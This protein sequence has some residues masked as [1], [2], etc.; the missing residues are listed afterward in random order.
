[1]TQTSL[2]A[3]RS[4]RRGEKLPAPARRCAAVRSGTSARPKGVAFQHRLRSLTR[5]SLCFSSTSAAHQRHPLRSFTRAT[6]LRPTDRESRATPFLIANPRLTFHLGDRK[7][8]PLEISNRQFSR[9]L[10]SLCLM[11]AFYLT[12]SRRTSSTSQNR[13]SSPLA[14][15][16]PRKSFDFISGR[17]SSFT[18]SPLTSH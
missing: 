1:M 13:N 3:A 12:S 5:A 16:L 2:S 17:A 11:P 9:V 4:T 8:S 10:L 7:I 18:P 15:S 6:A 14:L